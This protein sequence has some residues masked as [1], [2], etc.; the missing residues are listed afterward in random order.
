MIDVYKW[1]PKVKSSKGIVVGYHLNGKP[2]P[3]YYKKGKLI[4]S[5]NRNVGKIDIIKALA[6]SSNSYFSILAGDY[7][8]SPKH[9]IKAAKKLNIGRKTNIELPGEIKGNLPDDISY[10]KTSLYSFAIG[11]HSLVTTPLQVA[12]MFSILANKGKFYKPEI[13]KSKKELIRTISMPLSVRN[14]ILEGLHKALWSEKGTARANNIRKLIGN[15][16]LLK[17]YKKL[18]HRFVGKTS[19]AEIMYKK[20]VSQEK[21]V[22][23]NHAWFAGISFE[24]TKWEK[25]ELVVIVYL[26]FGTSGKEA[27]PIA[28]EIIHKYKEIKN[29]KF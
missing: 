14:T 6:Q 12:C 17:K 10:N 26:R 2:F 19:T 22:K 8:K 1:D 7:I 27:A 9:L 5:K 21:A 25:P 24:D 20:D 3:R 15:P 18:K 28:A 11:Q 23:H 13:I 4:P 29:V 16:I